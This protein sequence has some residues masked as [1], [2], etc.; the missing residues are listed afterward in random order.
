MQPLSYPW[1]FSLSLHD[2]SLSGFLLFTGGRD[3]AARLIGARARKVGRGLP[4]GDR[5]G[6]PAGAAAQ[7]GGGQKDDQGQ[8]N[9]DGWR[10]PLTF[11]SIDCLI[12]RWW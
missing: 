12:L 5:R 8:L 2:L 9:Q 1:R 7:G 3:P 11:D 6:R 10:A 4:R